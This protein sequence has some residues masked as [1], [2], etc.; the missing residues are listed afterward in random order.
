M[1]QR[2]AAGTGP[3][4]GRHRANRSDTDLRTASCM[5]AHPAPAAA[6]PRSLKRALVFGAAQCVARN[7]LLSRIGGRATGVEPGPSNHPTCPAELIH[8]H[9]IPQR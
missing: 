8:E 4:A 9:P 6:L 7:P 2:F 3:R 1:P 5:T